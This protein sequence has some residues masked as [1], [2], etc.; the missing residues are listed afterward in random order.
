MNCLRQ[1][2]K[3]FYGNCYTVYSP[4]DGQP[5]MDHD[6]TEGEGVS[7]QGYTAVKFQIKNCRLGPPNCF[8]GRCQ[9]TRGSSLL[10]QHY[11]QKQFTAGLVVLLVHQSNMVYTKSQKTNLHCDRPSSLE[12]GIS[13]NFLHQRQFTKTEK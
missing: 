7:P 9:V 13:R 5:C 10:Q 11:G 8:V 12:H 2:N 1:L 6:R 3:I 4:K